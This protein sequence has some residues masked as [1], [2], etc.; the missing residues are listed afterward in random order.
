MPLGKKRDYQK[1]YREYHG[2]PDQI[3]RRAGRNAA[4]RKLKRTRGMAALRGKD[5]NHRDGNTWNNK[6]GNLS[7]ESKSV[8]R[9][10]KY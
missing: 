5:I 10:R 4:R 1:E 9:G 3:H 7:V 6:S 2:K 8:N